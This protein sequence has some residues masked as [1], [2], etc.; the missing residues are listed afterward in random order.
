[1]PT[2]GHK[3]VDRP[4]KTCYTTHTLKLKELKWKQQQS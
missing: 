1:M 4:G 2:T 3:G